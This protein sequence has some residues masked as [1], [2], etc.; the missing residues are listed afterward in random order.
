MAKDRNSP[1]Q[2]LVIFFC[3]L[4]AIYD[5]FN[6]LEFDLQDCQMSWDDQSKSNQ[7]SRDEFEAL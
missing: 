5:C 4:T 7:N 3:K 1:V 2:E 6:E